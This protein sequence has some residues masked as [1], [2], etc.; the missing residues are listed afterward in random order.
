MLGSIQS[1]GAWEAEM[2]LNLFSDFHATVGEQDYGFLGSPVFTPLVD[3]GRGG[4]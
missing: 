3:L 2:A 1:R 4:K